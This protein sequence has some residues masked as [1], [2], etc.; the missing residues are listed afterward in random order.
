VSV[1]WH[2]C[3]HVALRVLRRLHHTLRISDQEA[4]SRS[5]GR[6]YRDKIEGMQEA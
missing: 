2:H 5:R 1:V 3:V 6:P 4:T